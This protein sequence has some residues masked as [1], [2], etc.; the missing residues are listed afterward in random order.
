VLQCDPLQERAPGV[1]RERAEPEMPM[2][3][4]YFD[5]GLGN[6]HNAD[7][8]TSGTRRTTRLFQQ[9]EGFS[10]GRIL[11]P[12]IPGTEPELQSI[13]AFAKLLNMRPEMAVLNLGEQELK[14]G[15]TP[16]TWCR[17]L[18]FY[19][20][21]CLAAGIEPVLLAYP[22]IPGIEPAVSRQTALLIKELGLIL[23]VP[24]VD[25]YSMRILEEVNTRTWF[26]D[27]VAGHQTIN[28]QGKQWL[29]DK[30]IET[31]LKTDTD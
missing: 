24:V 20:Q 16:L 6:T 5:D 14:D 26:E 9:M 8:R 23:G 1:E 3:L 28:Q 31:L 27:A 13:A 12:E 22:E 17:Q 25:L 10:A 15:R 11:L 29:A 19:A 7:K 18:L 30:V 4:Y 2:K 21:T